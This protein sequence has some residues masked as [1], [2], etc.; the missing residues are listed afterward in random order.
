[1]EGR[2]LARW[3]VPAVGRGASVAAAVSREAVLRQV[4]GR[5]TQATGVLMARWRDGRIVELWHF[6]DWMGW[7]TGAGRDRH[8][9]FYETRDNL[10][11]VKPG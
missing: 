2:E 8:L 10:G 6:G 4:R 5:S 1:M 3:Q 7:L 11:T 9:N